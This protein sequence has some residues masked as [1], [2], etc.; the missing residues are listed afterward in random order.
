LKE[1]VDTRLLV[2][3][4][5]SNQTEIKRKTARKLRELIENREGILPTLTIC[6]IVQ[7]TCERRGR[8]EAETRYASLIGSGL[9][10]QDLDRNIAKEAGLLKCRYKTI[11]IGDCIIAATALTNKAKVVSD[12]PHFDTIKETERTW[13]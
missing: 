12:D 9:Q 7:L 5:Y 6:E 4:F 13:I 10:I 2:E 8:E 1:V 11:P 3:H